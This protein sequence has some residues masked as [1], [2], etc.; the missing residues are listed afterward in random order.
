MAKE[1]AFYGGNLAD[2]G[3]TFLSLD[4]LELLPFFKCLLSN[5]FIKALT[6]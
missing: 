6:L 5:L 3:H 4:S 1:G 2:S